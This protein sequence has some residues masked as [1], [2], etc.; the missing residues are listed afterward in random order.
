MG[1]GTYIYPHVIIHSPEKVSLGKNVIVN[2]F[3]HI[4]GGGEV[5]IGNDVMIAAHSVLTSIT[6]DKYSRPYSSKNILRKIVIEENVWICSSAV[7]LPGVRVQK[8][9]I[10]G[11]GAVVTEDVPE[12]SIVVGV[13]A[14]DVTQTK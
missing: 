10:V 1:S 9:S 4:W 2:N 3:V 5:E 7:I 8:H 12:N 14:R 11:A 13:P 6:H